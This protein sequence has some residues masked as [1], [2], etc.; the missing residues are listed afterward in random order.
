MRRTRRSCSARRS[1]RTRRSRAWTRSPTTR[2][3]RS[4]AVSAGSS[5]WPAS[6]RTTRR[7]SPQRRRIGGLVP[8]AGLPL[9]ELQLYVQRVSDRW[10]IER[11]HV[12]AGAP[13]VV[14]L[15]SPGFDGVPWL[16]RVRQAGALWGADATGGR[17]EG[18]R[19]T[20]AGLERTLE[21]PPPVRAA[22]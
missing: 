2:S 16:E 21:D 6:A 4:R 18:H 13:C 12:G 14:V 3:S 1:I 8:D 15:V 17:A 9:R 11:A 5:P 7:S 10:P 22:G 19:Y 20:P